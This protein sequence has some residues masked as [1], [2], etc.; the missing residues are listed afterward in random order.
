MPGSI[1]A[2]TTRP[3]QIIQF[4]EDDHR[5]V[6]KNKATG[7]ELKELISCT[8]LIGQYYEA[9]DAEKVSLR[10]ARQKLKIADDGLPPSQ[11]VLE[12]AEE[13]K[14]EWA[15]ASTYGT[16]V[17]EYMEDLIK[18]RPPR[19]QP[20]DE[21]ER[22][23]FEYGAAF[24]RRIKSRLYGFESEKIVCDYDWGIAG[25]VDLIARDPKADHLIM[26]DWKTNKKI[27]LDTYINKY[28]YPPVDHIPDCEFGHYS[29]QLNLYEAM[30]KH[31]GYYPKE[32]KFLK[33]LIHLHKDKGVTV[34]QVPDRQREVHDLVNDHLSKINAR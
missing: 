31:A 11:A 28:C 1:I 6:I 27:D 10:K 4:T 29:L 9:F 2:E 25:T 22:L 15:G 20:Q 23:V 24:I 30:L 8:T 13:F 12:C 5:Y 34:I 32:I 3:G 18:D 21:R 16:R 17:H 26:M 19:N 33:Y 14:R 7:E